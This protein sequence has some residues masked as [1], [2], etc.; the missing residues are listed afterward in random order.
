MINR[1]RTTA[2][3]AVAIIAT[4]VTLAFIPTP[5][6]HARVGPWSITRGTATIGISDVGQIN[7]TPTSG[8]GVA[9]GGGAA[10]KKVLSGTASVDFTALAAALAKTSTSL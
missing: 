5:F 7:L 9:I 1:I 8:K 6:T 10:I 4:L 2:L 3:R